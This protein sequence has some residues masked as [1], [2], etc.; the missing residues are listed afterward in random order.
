MFPICDR[1]LSCLQADMP[2]P[3]P[4][5]QM[6]LMHDLGS[7]RRTTGAPHFFSTKRK[8][9][10]LSKHRK[11]IGLRPGGRIFTTFLA[12]I[13][14]G[15]LDVSLGRSKIVSRPFWQSDT[16]LRSPTLPLSHCQ[17]SCCTICF[18]RLNLS[19]KSITQYEDH[20]RPRWK[21]ILNY[22]TAGKRDGPHRVYHAFYTGQCS[23]A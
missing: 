1:P 5:L 3:S 19:I 18:S 9:L 7:C 11:A 13:Q 23:A 20:H 15:T 2:W 4:L 6:N 16:P 10:Q 17:S 14:L 22:Q 12:C 8:T 21:V